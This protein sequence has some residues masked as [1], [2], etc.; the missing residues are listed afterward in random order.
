VDEQNTS[1]PHGIPQNDWDVTPANVKALV[2]VLIERMGV[3]EEQVEFLKERLNTN[4]R[5]SSKPPSQDPPGTAPRPAR[6]KSKRKRGGQPGHKGHARVLFPPEQCTRIEDH[7]PEACRR[8]GG[9]LV[10]DDP[11]PYR[12]QVV[13]I[14][15]VAPTIEE[16][17]LHALAC[18]AC[19]TVTR[20][21]MPADVEVVG[22]G[23]RL[24][25]IVGYMAIQFGASMRKT[26][27]AMSDLFGVQMAHSTVESMRHEQSVAVAPAVEEALEYVRAQPVALADE[28]GFMQGNGD[29]RNPG[30]LRA[31]MWVAVTRLVVV[32]RI[33]LSRSAEDAKALLGADFAGYLIS[34]RYGGY[35]WVQT[36]KRQLCWS[37]LLRDFVKISERAGASGRIGKCLLEEGRQLFVL[38]DRIKQGTLSRE[39]FR[40]RVAPIRK[41]VRILLEAGAGYEVRTG[42]KT[43]RA[44]TAR[45]CKNLLKLEPALWLFVRVEGVEPTNNEA[46]R[47]VRWGVM[48]RRLMQGTQSE[49]GSDFVARMLTVL[50]TLRRQNRNVLE[51]L[52]EAIEARRID[53]AP[54]SLLPTL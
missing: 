38:W 17:R 50:L 35:A 3:F 22:Y 20:A 33:T 7:R 24:T 18:V 44:K 42:D 53:A 32:F 1:P 41:R 51:Y 21:V 14:P 34:D 46:E 13:E 25:A 12:H 39:V 19:G 2:V 26:A 40:R 27:T 49:H 29:G 6:K 28:T 52:T 9:E 4:S 11:N 23:P 48:L 31:W 30:K 43:A 36:C 16:H 5:N 54:P 10:G 15:P 45:T 47:S 37:H 8:C